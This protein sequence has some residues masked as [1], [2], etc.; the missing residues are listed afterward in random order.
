M[1]NIITLYH[2]S[3]TIV[4]EPDLEKSRIDI[5]FGK[6]FYLAE[7]FNLPAKWACKNVKAIVNQYTFKLEGLNVYE[8]KLDA[9]WLN[10]VASNRNSKELTPE[11]KRISEAD[12][13]IGAVADDK[14]FHILDLYD[15]GVI[16]EEYAIKAMNC[17]NYGKQYVLKT[18]KAI[19]NLM[20][21]AYYKIVGEEKDSFLRQF[22]TDAKEASTKTKAILQEMNERGL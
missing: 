16:S 18:E 3:N 7:E 4:P 10:F 11:L 22:K 19:N 6:G 14:L 1:N 15:D 13:I 17:M 5:D 21:E 8:F 20:F 2:G 9:S 12:V